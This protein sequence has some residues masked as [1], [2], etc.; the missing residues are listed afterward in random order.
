MYVHNFLTF[1]G[2]L[3]IFIQISVSVLWCDLDEGDPL[4]TAC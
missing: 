3:V 1:C 4:I 2:S